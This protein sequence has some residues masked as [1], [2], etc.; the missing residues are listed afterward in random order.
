MRVSPRS[1]KQ[2][3]YGADTRKRL[4]HGAQVLAKTTAVTYGPHGRNCI[5]DRMAGLLAT[6]DGVTVAREVDL[7]DPVAQ[8]G[9]QILKEACVNVNATAGDG[10][11]STVV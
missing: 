8:M 2:I 9:C 7:A 5:L 10:T 3:L 6:K 4:L 1:P 11:T